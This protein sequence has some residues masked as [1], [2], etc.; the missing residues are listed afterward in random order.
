M[1]AMKC[2]PATADDAGAIA[3]LHTDS[4]RR[5]YRGAFRDE[6]LDGDAP[7]DRLAVWTD[8]LVRPAPDACTIVADDDGDVVGFAHVVFEDDPRWARCSTTCT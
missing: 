1:A 3:A 8:R 4:W 5:N 6:Y 2:R 7:A